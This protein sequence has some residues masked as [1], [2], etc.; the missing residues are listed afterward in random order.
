[1]I[2]L[3][4]LKIWAYWNLS[5]MTA[6]QR[7]AQEAYMDIAEDH[8]HGFDDQLQDILEGT[9]LADISHAGEA[10]GEYTDT[11]TQAS[12]EELWEALRTSHK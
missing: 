10:L 11:Q 6:A 4:F 9:T 8:G 5:D 7:H 2:F 3:L 12:N 1:M